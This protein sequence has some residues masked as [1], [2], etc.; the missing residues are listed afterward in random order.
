[1]TI[2]TSLSQILAAAFILASIVGG[3]GL[4]LLNRIDA[5]ED[6][7]S[8]RITDNAADAQRDINDLAS[9]IGKT[10]GQ[11]ERI[12]ETGQTLSPISPVIRGQKR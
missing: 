12:S 8:T 6:R 5:A 1:M 11:L 3:G 2:N 9:R 4:F 10:E 7:L